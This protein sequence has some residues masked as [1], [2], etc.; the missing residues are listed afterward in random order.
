VS[1]AK[2]ADPVLLAVLRGA[3]LDLM[4]TGDTDRVT[5]AV[6]RH[7]RTLAPFAPAGD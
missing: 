7:L 4:A 6:E 5:R 2:T 3:F 1:Q